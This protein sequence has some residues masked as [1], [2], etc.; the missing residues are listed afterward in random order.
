MATAT[1]DATRIHRLTVINRQMIIGSIVEIRLHG[2]SEPIEGV[3][4]RIDIAN[5][6]GWGYYGQAEILTK[7][8]RHQFIDY[9]D[10][11]SVQP[12]WTKE[13]AEEYPEARPIK[14]PP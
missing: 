10:V 11:E 12:T 6:G 8:G 5:S 2:K 9:L 4:R 3:V 13:K 1:A 14:P 7:N